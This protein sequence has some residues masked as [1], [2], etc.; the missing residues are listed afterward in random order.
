MRPTQTQCLHPYCHKQAHGKNRFGMLRIELGKE[1]QFLAPLS[2]KLV[3]GIG[4]KGSARMNRMGV[5][6]VSDL[7]HYHWNY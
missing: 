5:K 1:Q 2:I 7:S 6:S 4:P 3:L